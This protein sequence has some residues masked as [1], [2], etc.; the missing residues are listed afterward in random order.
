[1]ETE[2][3]AEMAATVMMRTVKNSENSGN[4]EGTISDDD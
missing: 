3:A 2:V 1:M 4:S